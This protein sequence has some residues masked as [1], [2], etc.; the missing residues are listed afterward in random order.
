MA[1]KL[2]IF[3]SYTGS[4]L[5]LKTI[6]GL[7]KSQLIENV[8]FL[9]PK[10]CKHDL[11]E[12][13]SLYI[14]SLFSTKSLNLICENATTD[15]ILFITKEVLINLFPNAIERLVSV[16]KDTNAGIVYSDFYETKTGETN[17]HPLIDYHIGS[18]RDD[19]NFGPMTLIRK[20][21]FLKS[22]RTGSDNYFYAGLY[23]A[24][25]AL[26]ENYPIIR[27]PEFLYEI[28]VND[29]IDPAV[30]HFEY[31]DPK[32]REAQIEMEKAAT[33]HLK[34]IG[35]YLTPEF[36]TLNSEN[37]EF[38]CEISV[39]IPVKDRARTI[40]DAVDSV[41]KQQAD[42][43][44]NLIIVDNHSTDGTTEIINRYSALDDR[45]IH[46]I[47]ETNYLGIGG[48]WNEAITNEKCGRYCIQ[49][50][51]DDVYY[52]ENVLQKVV[53]L[54]HQGK[55]AMIVGSYKVTDFRLN[56]QPPGLV[57]HKEWTPENGRNNAL[58]INGL[59][60]PRAFY[61]PLI[62]KIK[63][64]NV[65]YG[66]DYASCL[67]IS[68]KYQVGRIYDPIYICRRWE[69]NSDAVLSIEKQN[70]FNTYKDKL[71]ANEILARQQLN[72]LKMKP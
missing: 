51:S 60:A 26:S 25:L 55:Y 66:E 62:R 31:V 22:V 36:D 56:D 40:C 17:A 12:R 15:L 28:V 27:I 4:D 44:F 33:N 10:E 11:P 61:T 49:L 18:I 39:I 35:A 5:A 70:I 9:S 7:K 2:T 65:S 43:P 34:R 6:E 67:A 48:C 47:P 71:R 37:E 42:F 72:R 13:N 59:G 8:I 14:D 21:A 19:F 57:I 68:R 41:L 24:R 58:R 53:D 1:S 16:I 20:E 3:Q 63:F 46:I 54:F 52:D 29:T 64:P 50:D 45:I 32:N 23:N 69:G 38:D 30:K